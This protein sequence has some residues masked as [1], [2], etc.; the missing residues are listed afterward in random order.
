VSNQISAL[1]RVDKNELAAREAAIVTLKQQNDLNP[2]LMVPAK[3]AAE[4]N[5]FIASNFHLIKSVVSI[6][7][8]VKFW[9]E[10]E[11]LSHDG[12]SL[13]LHNVCRPD[14]QARHEHAG[15]LF[16]DLAAEVARV[17]REERSREKNSAF[18][19]E[20]RRWE[21]EKAT[22]GETQEAIRKVRDYFKPWNK[23]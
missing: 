22:A 6:A 19:A 9:V 15:M 2:L 11:G 20:M 7:T 12:L 21:K 5:H 10:V 17:L 13:A 4:V 14:R 1:A 8:R 23:K 18:Q 3:L 16:A